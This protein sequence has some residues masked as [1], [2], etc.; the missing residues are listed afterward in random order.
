M[1]K[2]KPV[3]A[4]AEVI[5]TLPQRYVPD[6]PVADLVAWPGNPKDHDRG[7][8][9]ESMKVNGFYGALLVQDWPKTPKYILAGHG[10]KDT[11]VEQ[12]VET[13]PALLVKCDPRTARRIVLV[14]NRSSQLGGFQNDSLVEFLKPLAMAGDLAGTGYDADD[15]DSLVAQ[16][17][18]PVSFVAR[19]TH[20]CPQ[21]GHVFKSLS[22]LPPGDRDID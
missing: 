15:L 6:F 10:R 3:A 5:R 17:E 13:V 20:T 7:A 14:D 21:C 12:G 22:R 9:T 4:L 18:T 8:I 11:L 2:A 16:V 19:D 1:P